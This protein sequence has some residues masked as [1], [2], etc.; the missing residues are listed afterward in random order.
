MALPMVLWTIA[1]LAGITLLLAGIV[2]GWITEETRE[3]KQFRARQ[4]ALSGLA[5]AMNPKV[6][7]GDPLLRY[8]SADGEEGYSVLMK[9]ESGLINPNSLLGAAPDRRDLLGKLFAAWGLDAITEETAADGLY[10]WQSS[11]P[12]KSLHGAK[13]SEYA[14]EGQAGFPPGSPFI[15]PEEM[16]LVLGFDPVMQAKTDWRSYF[17]T[18]YIGKVNILHAPKSILTDFLGLT[19][20]QAD[21]WIALRS[22]KDGI[23]GTKDDLK[24]DTIGRAVTLIGCN[25]AQRAM[26]LD[27]C[28]ISGSV[29][30]IESTGFC[31]GV[32]R[33]ISVIL[34]GGSTDDAQAHGNLLEWSEQ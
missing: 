9:D 25:G 6:D 28:G 22:G 24:V 21:Q 4:Q 15:S 33:R 27:A 32:K 13:S 17:T 16:A 31:Y 19:G 23:D 14:A 10:D 18:H 5:L 20:E 26:I 34:A 29:R 7:P 11:S 8:H 2:Q 30:R 1:L 3:G 12:F